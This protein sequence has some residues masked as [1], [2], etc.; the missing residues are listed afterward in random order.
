LYRHQP[1]DLGDSVFARATARLTT[2]LCGVLLV[3]AGPSTTAPAAV[4]AARWAPAA[5]AKIHPGVQMFTDGAQCTSNFVFT[6]R[7]NRVYVGYAAHCAGLGGPASTNGC[8]TASHP[9]GTTVRFGTG[10]TLLSEGTTVGYGKL[11]YSSWRSMRSRGVTAEN[12][13]SYNDFALVRVNAAY[14]GRVN[15]SVPHWGGPVGLDTDGVPTGSRVYSVGSSSMRLGSAP[16]PKTGTVNGV[17]GGGWTYMVRTGNPGIPGD[18]G[19]G[20]LGPDGRAMGTLSTL[21]LFPQTLSN[22]VGNLHRELRYAQRWS[23]IVGLRL[24]HGTQPFSTS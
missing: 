21:A 1:V 19:S 9:I 16:V 11:A 10:S 15:P 5:T 6:D 12:L 17:G 20:F 13:C 22:G 7:R 3:T 4:G 18:S 24:V 14:V 2:L 23:G 8:E